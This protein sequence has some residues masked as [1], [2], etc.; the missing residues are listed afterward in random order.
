MKLRVRSRLTT[1]AIDAAQ[2]RRVPVCRLRRGAAAGRPLCPPRRRSLAGRRGQGGRARGDP[3]RP[4]RVLPDDASR[5]STTSPRTREAARSRGSASSATGSAAHVYPET[6]LD[7]RL[8]PVSRGTTL[9]RSTSATR[10]TRR[11]EVMQ[12]RCSSRLHTGR[13]RTSSGAS[14]AHTTSSRGRVRMVPAARS[15]GDLGLPGATM[16]ETMPRCSRPS[17]APA[18]AARADRIDLS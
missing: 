1:R 18:R 4:A 13:I 7:A 16:G 14:A 17:E 6:Q 2:R 11:G 15:P 12:A 5:S 10:S 8:D 3:R 9:I